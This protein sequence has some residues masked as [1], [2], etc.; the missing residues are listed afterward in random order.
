MAEEE[1]QPRETPVVV[2]T[3]QETP[4]AASDEVEELSIEYR[5]IEHLVECERRFEALESRLAE[6]ESAGSTGEEE[7]RSSAGNEEQESEPE[8]EPEPERPPKPSHWYFRR[9]GE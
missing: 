7:A 1:T 6:L 4:S 2:V 3:T 5:F 9:I 8:P